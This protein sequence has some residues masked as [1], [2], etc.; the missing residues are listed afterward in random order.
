VLRLRLAG[1]LVEV[2]VRVV[3]L[4]CPFAL[5]GVVGGA[6][7]L[8]GIESFSYPVCASVMSL[9][10]TMASDGDASITMGGV[11]S[12]L[13]EVE[14][15]VADDDEAMPMPPSTCGTPMAWSVSAVIW[16][17][18]SWSGSVRTQKR[19][20]QRGHLWS[21]LVVITHEMRTGS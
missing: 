21:M 18:S 1:R 5:T 13:V 16:S 14:V 17:W 20:W 3:A 11:G 7:S 2:D 6:V 15:S 10:T 12:A 8:S 19:T 4:F 9:V